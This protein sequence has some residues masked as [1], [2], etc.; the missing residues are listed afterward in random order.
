MIAADKS[1]ATVPLLDLSLTDLVETI[2]ANAKTLKNC[3]ED[4]KLPQPSLKADGPMRYPGGAESA[5][6]EE[7]RFNLINAAWALEQMASGPHDWM[8]W[9][10]L[11]VCVHLFQEESRLADSSRP[12]TI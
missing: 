11:T 5:K 7:A 4:A 9:Q 12:N 10:G 3:L 2:S 1:K 6:L 8:Y